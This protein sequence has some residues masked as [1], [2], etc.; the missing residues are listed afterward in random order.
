LRSERLRLR[1]QVGLGGAGQGDGLTRAVG[2]IDEDQF[3]LHLARARAE[4][5]GVAIGGELE[6]VVRE[7]SDEELR[8][9]R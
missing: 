4:A 1:E 3:A 5:G 9:T 8:F 6:E 7:A 2:G